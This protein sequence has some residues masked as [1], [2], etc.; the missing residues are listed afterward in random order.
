MTNNGCL[1]IVYRNWPDEL[2]AWLRAEKKL[3][4]MKNSGVSDHTEKVL[5]LEFSP[6]ERKILIKVWEYLI[7]EHEKRHGSM[8]Y[9]MDKFGPS[10]VML[11]LREAMGKLI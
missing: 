3:N 10:I 4:T 7:K 1:E 9:L 6:E 2:E 11:A 5:D 8:Y